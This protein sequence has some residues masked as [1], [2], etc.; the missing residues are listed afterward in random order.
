[1]HA[2]NSFVLQQLQHASV[3]CSAKNF[4][5]RYLTFNVAKC[6]QG[7]LMVERGCPI[8]KKSYGPC[9]ILLDPPIV[10]ML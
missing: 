4:C 6:L 2:N 10:P 8:T 1:M 9:Q 3:F 5:H 7:Y